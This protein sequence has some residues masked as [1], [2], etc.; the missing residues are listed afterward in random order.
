MS[1]GAP[2]DYNPANR[3]GEKPA[4]AVKDSKTTR[5]L[6]VGD[7]RENG[8]EKEENKKRATRDRNHKGSPL[9]SGRHSGRALRALEVEEALLS[10]YQIGSSG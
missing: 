5:K 10:H 7:H 2:E 1:C 3:T 6:T 8:T 4:N 9:W